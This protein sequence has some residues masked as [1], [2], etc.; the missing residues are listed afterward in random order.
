M[1]AINQLNKNEVLELIHK[2]QMIAVVR[3]SEPEKALKLGETAVRAG[4]TSVE[5]TAT[6]PSYDKVVTQLRATF[7]NS[8]VVG[9]GSILSARQLEIALDAGAQFVVTPAVVKDMVISDHLAKAVFIVGALSPSEILY[10]EDMGSDLVK[11][12]PVNAV[13]GISYIKSILEPM[14][15]L[16]LVPTGGVNL[17]N[18]VSFIHAGATCVGL[19]SSLFPKHLVQEENWEEIGQHIAKFVV[20]LSDARD[21]SGV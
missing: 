8:A 18:F 9:V 21:N 7:G 6:V 14:P 1:G 19:G 2:T 20:R 5:I 17:D 11:V 12:F 4:I 15:W 13:G 16:K 10:A 3:H